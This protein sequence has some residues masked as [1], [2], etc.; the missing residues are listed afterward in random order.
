LRAEVAQYEE[1]FATLKNQ[2]VSIRRLE[3][4]VAVLRG[5]QEEAIAAATELRTNEVLASMA[6]LQE[7]AEKQTQALM[8]ALRVAQ[9]QVRTRGVP[10]TCA[11]GCVMWDVGCVMWDVGCVMCDVGCGMCDV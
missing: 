11:M 7:Q 2:D 10:S 4:E 6:E 3:E 8:E 5:V 1:E 9:A